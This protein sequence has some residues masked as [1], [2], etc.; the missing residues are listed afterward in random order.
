MSIFQSSVI[1]KY[2]KEQ[3][4]QANLKHY[5]KY[6]K[7]FH[8][9]EIQQNIQSS[10]EEQYQ[11]KFLDEL[12]VNI[13]GYTL[14]PSPKFNLTTEFKNKKNARKADGAILFDEQAI[15]VIELKST[16]TKDLESITKQAFDYK[17]NQPGC[18]YVITSN[19]QKLRFYINNAVY[20]EEFDLFN[21]TEEK[22]YLM[23][24]C[25]SKNSILSNIPLKIK[26][27]SIIVEEKITKTFYGDYSLFK[28]EL[29]RDIIK[30]NL[31]S[32]HLKELD[33]NTSKMA[34]FKKTQK[35]LD[36][37]L[38][39]FFGEDR[40]LLPPNSVPKILE[41]WR[42]LK[43]MDAYAPLYDRY[44]KY[45]NYLNTGWNGK[46]H[47]I[48]AYNGGLF[49]PDNILDSIKISDELLDKHTAV[50]TR[51]DFES[52]VDVNILGHIF[53]HSLNEIESVNAQIGGV[54]FD[55]QKAKRKKDGVYYTPKYITKYIVDKTLGRLCEEKK[56]SFGINEEDYL[57]GRKNRNKS[58]ITALEQKLKEY[59]DW[60][61][62]LKIIDPACGS[63]AFLNQA[64]EYLI[65]EHHWIDEMTSKLLGG[66]IVFQDIENSILENNIFGVDLNEESV[67]IAKLSLWLRTAQ[68][69]RKLTS[70]ND[71]IQCGN[72]LISIIELAESKAFDWEKAFPSVFEKGGFDIVIGN[73]P[74]GAELDKNTQKYLNT[75][76]IKGGSE[77][78]ISFLKLSHTILRD[79]GMLGFI[80]P[81]SFSYSSNYGPIRE[82]LLEDITEIVDCKKVWSD[83]KLEQVI[84]NFKKHDPTKEYLSGIREGQDILPVGLI[85]KETF[86]MFGFL[87]NGISDKEKK[88]GLKIKEGRLTL[89]DIATNQRGGTYQKLIQE[90][91][92]L[93]VLAGANVQRHGVIGVKGYL[94]SSVFEGDNKS[95]IKTN[96]ILAQNIVS[97][98]EN[99]VDHVKIIATEGSNSSYDKTVLIDTINQITLTDDRYNDT[100]IKEI[101][102]S[103]IINWYCY[104]FIFGKAIRTMHFDNA[105]TS[106]IPIPTI[107]ASQTE[108]I[109]DL[110]S[111]IVKKQEELLSSHTT[112][113]RYLLQKYFDTDDEAKKLDKW[114]KLTFKQLIN[115][116]KKCGSVSLNQDSELELFGQFDNKV[117]SNKEFGEQ[118]EISRIELNKLIYTL[119]DLS[120]E[121]M[122]TIDNQMP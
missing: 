38:F 64:L 34:L 111:K 18:V 122:N 9:F 106:R 74:Y 48:F 84:V 82:F 12:F 98:V 13:L 21:L 52:Q 83:V 70:L 85:N 110:S 109:L 118:I 28:R 81:K 114:E 119:Y 36:R 94:N 120:S 97:H 56:Q 55:K 71:N 58:S 65:L 89:N 96:S 102:N 99:P 4:S 115:L 44:K 41:Q 57:K 47:K 105:V 67:E 108:K 20:Y 121:E 16:K 80:I 53:E 42:S 23:Y 10:K 33:E 92:D 25:L 51:Y 11:A 24:L 2:I 73:P 45:F 14:N 104:R 116:I 54:E 40:G 75:Y 90:Q 107:E 49:K 61:L 43:E 91:G 63:G 19:F 76:Y 103:K 112:Y 88:I 101:L 27:E 35:L 22:F 39:L 29:Y 26:E 7:Y 17:V 77:T 86:H 46:D 72:S 95:F 87:L 69:G 100:L 117:K 78:V 1:A 68:K 37:F 30:K 93:P 62:E 5:Q 31:R 50:L 59:R 15:A 32:E 8:N 3:E 60:L 66:G 6:V 113:S 79:K